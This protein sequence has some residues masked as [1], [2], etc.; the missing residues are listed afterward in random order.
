MSKTFRLACA[1]SSYNGGTRRPPKPL[2]LL[3]SPNTHSFRYWMTIYYATPPWITSEQIDQMRR[4][5]LDCPPGHHVDHIVPLRGGIVCGLHVP[6]NLQYLPNKVNLFKS[7]HM[8]P[9][10][11]NA[12][13]EMFNLIPEPHQMRLDL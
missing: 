2:W 9:G 6:W 7:N 8:W 1:I 12:P 10:H 4:F 11:P 3:Q 5:Y 13:A